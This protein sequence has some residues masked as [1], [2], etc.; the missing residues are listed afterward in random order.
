[1]PQEFGQQNKR[2]NSVNQKIRLTQIPT[3]YIN[4][5]G[6][7]DR[8]RSMER[9]LT[10]LG[11]E[12]FERFPGTK[13]PNRVGC[14]MSH[15]ALLKKIIDENIYPALILED[16][17]EVFNFRKNIECPED[18]DSLYLGM[19]RLGYDTNIED[20]SHRSL[21]ISE[22]N[23]DYHRVHNMLARHAIIHMNKDYDQEAVEWM[24]KFIQE[25]KEYVAGDATLTRLIPK[26]K[27]YALNSPVFYQNDAGTRGLTKKSLEDCSYLEIDKV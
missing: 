18:T 7:T 17:L 23:S 19:S 9:L 14:S 20:G 27:V 8:K 5:D 21:R 22:K 1:L 10:N 26:Y 15:S 16:D 4:L 24:E 2:R 13:A 3:F 11:F 6:E 25:P 12:N